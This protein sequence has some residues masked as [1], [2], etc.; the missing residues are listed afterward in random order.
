MGKVKNRKTI[1]EIEATVLS[2]LLA[3]GNLVCNHDR[4]DAA[5]PGGPGL[6]TAPGLQVVTCFTRQLNWLTKELRKA[7]SDVVDDSNEG[8]FYDRLGDAVARYQVSLG[9]RRESLGG[10]TNAVIEEARKIA[11]EGL[12]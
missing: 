1:D 9:N 2:E 8:M 5:R 12:G 3:D 10:L 6:G 4:E 7:L 11:S